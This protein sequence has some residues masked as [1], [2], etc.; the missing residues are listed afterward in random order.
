MSISHGTKMVGA[1]L[2]G[3]G[4]FACGTPQVTQGTV[5]NANFDPAHAKFKKVCK[6]KVK[7]SCLRY[8]KKPDGIDDAD[9]DLQIK[10]GNHTSWIEVDDPDVYQA[11]PVGSQY[12]ACANP[13]A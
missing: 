1:A 12:P 7:S 10:D 9:Y 5:I 2:L 13:E 11:C 8:E 6:A 3:L 4:L